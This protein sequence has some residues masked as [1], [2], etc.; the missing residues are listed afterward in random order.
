MNNGFD[1]SRLHLLTGQE[2]AIVKLFIVN[3]Y[4]PSDIPKR[5]YSLKQRLTSSTQVY[6]Y[7]KDMYLLMLDNGFDGFI[8]SKGDHLV[9]AKYLK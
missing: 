6:I 7:Q 3:N 2:L 4:K 8:D 9:Y 5:A 1:K